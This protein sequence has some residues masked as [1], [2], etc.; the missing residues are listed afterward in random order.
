VST[1][2]SPENYPL[3]PGLPDLSKIP[4]EPIPILNKTKIRTLVRS[5]YDIQ[6]LRISVGNRI[7][8]NFRIKL[9]VNNNLNE[10]KD[11]QQK[12]NQKIINELKKN[13]KKITNLMIDNKS[14]LDK[15]ITN[16]DGIISDILEYKLIS[17]YFE[18]ENIE[19][20]MIKTLG[21]ELENISLWKYFL[22]DVKGCGPLMSGVIISEF[23]VSKARHSSSFLKYAGLDVA[24][25]GRGRGRYSEHL[26]KTSY[27]DKNGE[28]KEKMGLS[29]KPLV[30]TKLINVLTGCFLKSKNEIYVSI[31]EEY[32]QRKINTHAVK[33]GE[34]I[35]KTKKKDEDVI[36]IVNTYAYNDG[37]NGKRILL[38]ANRHMA[39]KFLINVWL[40]WRVLEGLPITLPYEQEFLKRNPHGTVN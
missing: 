11:E 38:M 29:Y 5:I 12:E 21:V 33:I 18:L 23:D 22:K 3:T 7:A 35:V 39:K 40:V 13:F 16:E 10:D 37:Y 36:K 27:I 19:V 17:H 6:K 32:R 8:T 4:Y 9:G 34:K 1:T 31:F 28:E 30:H 25:D 26:V 2:I 24:P 20:N 14:N 15:I